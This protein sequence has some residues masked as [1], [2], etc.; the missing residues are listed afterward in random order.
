MRCMK[1]INI[2][3]PERLLKKLDAVSKASGENRSVLIRQA[4][5]DYLDKQ[6]D[7]YFMKEG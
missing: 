1:P 7:K 2:K 4:L 5:H 6:I 3:M